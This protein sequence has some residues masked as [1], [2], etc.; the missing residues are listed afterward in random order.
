MGDCELGLEFGDGVAL[1]MVVN[2]LVNG[3]ANEGQKWRLQ[4]ELDTEDGERS[5]TERMNATRMVVEQ[6]EETMC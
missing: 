2:V 6:E 4:Q 1:V 5:G 3:R